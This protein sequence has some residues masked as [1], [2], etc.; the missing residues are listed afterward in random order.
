M[1]TT[2]KYRKETEN[3]IKSLTNFKLKS[4]SKSKSKTNSKSK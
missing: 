1:T 3:L 2:L 4:K